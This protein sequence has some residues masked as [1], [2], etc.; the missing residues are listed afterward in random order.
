MTSRNW[1][2]CLMRSWSSGRHR[3]SA[4]TNTCV[5]MQ[6]TPV[7]RHC[8]PSK[9][10]DIFPMSKAAAKRSPRSDFSPTSAPGDGSSRSRTVGSIASASCWCATRSSNEVSWPSII[11][12]PPSLRL[13]KC[14]SIS[15]LFTDKFLYW[16]VI[17]AR[18]SRGN[19]GHVYEDF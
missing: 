1:K 2:R 14:R 13:E 11:W 7:P 4:A 18:Q 12:P 16:N 9:P 5:P 17:K 6:V 15:T 3:L 10:T 19:N 8:R